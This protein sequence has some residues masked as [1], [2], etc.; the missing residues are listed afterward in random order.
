MVSHP[1]SSAGSW[2]AVLGGGGLGGGVAFLGRT[3]VKLLSKAAMRASNPESG[4]S[5]LTVLVPSSPLVTV[6]FPVKSLNT[7][8]PSALAKVPSLTGIHRG[9]PAGGGG[10]WGGA[11]R[12]GK[13]P[14]AAEPAVGVLEGTAP[15]SGAAAAAK[16][17][18]PPVA[19]APSG[20]EGAAG[21][22]AAAAAAAAAVAEG[23]TLAE[24]P[25]QAL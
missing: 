2:G 10:R 8:H 20:D 18:A 4:G 15:W 14:E 6:S 12:S 7:V 19:P 17:G 21:A 11:G 24:R 1:S 3:V 13:G 22:A 9:R 25:F 23:E 16:S 5:C